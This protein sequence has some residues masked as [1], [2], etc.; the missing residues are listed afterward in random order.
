MMALDNIV[1]RPSALSAFCWESAFCPYSFWRHSTLP[2]FLPLLVKPLFKLGPEIYPHKGIDDGEH[3]RCCPC[4]GHWPLTKNQILRWWDCRHPAAA[5]EI[6]STVWFLPGLL[7]ISPEWEWLTRPRGEVSSAAEGACW[8]SP[9][10]C[11]T[12]SK[13]AFLSLGPFRDVCQLFLFCCCFNC[14]FG[15]GI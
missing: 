1:K 13:A 15:F 3:L 10:G 4:K 7:E 8:D 11:L 14:D 12:S 2:L 9:G 6:Y 5:G